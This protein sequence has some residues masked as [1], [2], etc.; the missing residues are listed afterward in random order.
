[1]PKDPRIELHHR[2]NRGECPYAIILDLGLVDQTN[3]A[4]DE[5]G[6]KEV[7]GYILPKNKRLRGVPVSEDDKNKILELREQGIKISDIAKRT[8][9]SAMGIRR[10]LSSRTVCKTSKPIRMIKKSGETETFLSVHDA[11]LQTGVSRSGIRKCAI[12]E[13]K[14]AGKCKWEYVEDENV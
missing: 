5:L 10:I 6:L 13:L 7:G 2:Y 4:L 8:G 9:V 11:E 1:M 3:E 12:G 14:T